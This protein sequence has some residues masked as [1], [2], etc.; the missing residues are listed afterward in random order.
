MKSEFL[1]K[2]TN[3][4]GLFCFIVLFAFFSRV[5]E[6]VAIGNRNDL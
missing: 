3:R 4:D 1:C 6:D 5:A 2:I